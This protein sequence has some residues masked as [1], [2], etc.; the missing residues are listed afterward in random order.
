[1]GVQYFSPKHRNNLLILHDA[2]AKY[3]KADFIIAFT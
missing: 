3:L 1:M 2:I